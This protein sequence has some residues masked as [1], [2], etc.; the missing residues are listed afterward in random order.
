MKIEKIYISNYKNLKNLEMDFK[1]DNKIL[2]LVILT[3]SNGSGKTR[4]LEC[5]LNCFE[6]YINS[7]YRE[8]KNRLDIYFQ[9][10]EKKCFN[11][12]FDLEMFFKVLNRYN[13]K[14]VEPFVLGGNYKKD[15]F[16]EKGKMLKEKLEVLPKIIYVPTEINFQKMDTAS[17]TLVQKYRFINIVDTNLIKDIPSYIATK[18]ISEMFKNK[19]E[20]VEDIQRKVFDEINEIFEILEINVK[21]EDISQDGRN[22]PIF[23]NSAGEKFDINELS[24]GEKQLFLRTLA[25]KMLNPENSIILIDE[26]ELSLHPKWQQ[27]IV[28]VYKK[29]GKNNQIIIATHSPHILGSVKKENIILLDRSDDGKIMIKTDE[30]LYDSY[31]QPTDRVLKDIMGLESTRNPKIS[32]LLEEAG[33]L[34]D[35]DE[36]ENEKFKNKYNELREMLGSKDEDLLLMDMDIQIRKKR[37]SKNVENK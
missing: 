9:E 33:E 35:K 16:F 32:K 23:K 17:T 4:I 6:D 26:P 7:N 10:N 28:D 27:Q 11:E 8:D 1:K 19:N 22:I 14:K 37:G 29:I 3:G 24:S 12:S 5:I 34:I 36:Y 25:I 21:V 13:W 30:D 31:G 2:D 15:D 20:K 18:M